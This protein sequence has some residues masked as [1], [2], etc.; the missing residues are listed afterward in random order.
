MRM[1]SRPKYID[2]VKTPYFAHCKLDE[3]LL[4]EKLSEPSRNKRGGKITK[5]KQ[6]NLQRTYN[7]PNRPLY[8]RVKVL[9]MPPIKAIT[10]SI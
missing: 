10:I 2:L 9:L 7:F 5:G 3:L 4:V 8:F 6:M 1:G